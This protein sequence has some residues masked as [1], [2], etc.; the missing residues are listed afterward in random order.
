MPTWAKVLLA[1]F[2][3]LVVLF[4]VCGL[5]AF[6]WVTKN[7]DQIVAARNEG[8]EFGRGKDYV[9]CTDAA[10][11]RLGSSSVSAQIQTRMYADGCYSSASKSEELCANIPPATEI[12]KAAKWNVE[13][14][15]KRGI[16]N[17][18]G[19]IQVMQALGE[20]CRR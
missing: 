20:A 11:A 8:I 5:I 14:C 15:H 10:F 7:K 1:I 3:I 17:E 13:Q 18:Q 2:A 6:R 19:C 4:A 16:A 12:M 9:Q